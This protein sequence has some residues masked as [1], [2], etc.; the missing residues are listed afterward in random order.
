M[1]LL[2][3]FFLWIKQ[4]HVFK[5]RSDPHMEKTEIKQKHIQKEL[6][7]NGLNITMEYSLKIE[8]YLDVIL[9]CNDGTFGPY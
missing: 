2:S 7:D 5:S 8:N 1:F 3:K 4:S 6:K 9:K